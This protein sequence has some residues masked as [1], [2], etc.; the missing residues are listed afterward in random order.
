M[1]K[2]VSSIAEKWYQLNGFDAAIPPLA[3]ALCVSEG[4]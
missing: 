3:L 1:D 2:L 4:G